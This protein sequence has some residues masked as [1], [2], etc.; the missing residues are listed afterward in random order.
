M[1]ARDAVLDEKALL[2]RH[3]LLKALKDRF[4]FSLKRAKQTLHA[5]RKRVTNRKAVEGE[6]NHDS[7]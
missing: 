4:V 3:S 7:K 5:C 6:F 2:L 1:I